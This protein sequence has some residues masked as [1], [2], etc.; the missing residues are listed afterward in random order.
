MGGPGSCLGLGWLPGQQHKQVAATCLGRFTRLDRH[1]R[2][3]RAVVVI[4]DPAAR[5]YDAAQDVIQLGWY[6]CRFV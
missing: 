2:S 6:W 1:N 4:G 3:G 5:L